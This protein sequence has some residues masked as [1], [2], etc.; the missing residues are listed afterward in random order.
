MN[1]FDDPAHA[2][3]HEVFVQTGPGYY[4]TDRSVFCAGTRPLVRVR[5]AV[6]LV[7]GPRGWDFGWLFVRT[8]GFVECWLA[9]PY[10]LAFR[11]S[12]SRHSLRWFV[13]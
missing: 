8:D 13:R 5:P 12:R 10:S 11:K 4:H 2:T 9:D 6:P 7:Y 3:D 1:P